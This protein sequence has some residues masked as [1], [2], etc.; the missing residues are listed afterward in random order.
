M[1]PLWVRF[2]TEIRRR[3]DEPTAALLPSVYERRMISSVSKY[4][5]I[6]AKYIRML[7]IQ[8]KVWHQCCMK[9]LDKVVSGCNIYA[10]IYGM[11]GCMEG[12]VFQ[13]IVY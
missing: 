10:Y 6:F 3:I 5:C 7:E 12:I 11:M 13:N 8:M 1:G 4:L 9:S 2:R